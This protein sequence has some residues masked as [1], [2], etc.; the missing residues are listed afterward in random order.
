MQRKKKLLVAVAVLALTLATLIGVFYS[1][2]RNPPTSSQTH[3]D[4]FFTI[5]A[6]ITGYGFIEVRVVS[7]SSGVPVQGAK[8]SG[9]LSGLCETRRQL[10]VTNTAG[11]DY[12]ST[13][14][15]QVIYVDN[16]TMAGQGGWLAPILPDRAQGFGSFK[17][18]V[19]YGGRTYSFSAGIRPISITCVT[20]RVPSGNVT[21]PTYTY[22]SNCPS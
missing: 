18:D 8:M 3:A 6:H 9:V 13:T 16:F 1:E 10:N 20:L 12:V 5:C 15:T 4:T 14:E 19:R 2:E 11:Y 17:F 7:D 21:A 22:T